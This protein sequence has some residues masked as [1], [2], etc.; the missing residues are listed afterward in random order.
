ME[1]STL[2]VLFALCLLAIVEIVALYMG[3]DG[4]LL[5]VVIGIFGAVAGYEAKAKLGS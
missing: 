2:K 5:S 4:A 1:D 3:Y